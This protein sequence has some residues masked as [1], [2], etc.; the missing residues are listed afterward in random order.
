MTSHVAHCTGGIATHAHLQ[1]NVAFAMP[2]R[3]AAAAGY[4]DISGSS[5]SASEWTSDTL[6]SDSTHSAG[7]RIHTTTLPLGAASLAFDSSIL[8]TYLNESTLAE[9]SGTDLQSVFWQTG[10]EPGSASAPNTLPMNMPISSDASHLDQRML[11]RHQ[12][13]L[14]MEEER[15]VHDQH[16]VFWQTGLEPGSASAQQPQ[17]SRQRWKEQSSSHESLQQSLQRY[18]SSSNGSINSLQRWKEECIQ[19]LQRE[20]VGGGLL[21]SAPTASTVVPQNATPFT[22]TDAG[23]RQPVAQRQYTSKQATAAAPAAPPVHAVGTAESEQ[24][25]HE[26]RGKYAHSHGENSPLTFGVA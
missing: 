25:S 13:V 5:G 11:E 8:D 21:N 24:S 15:R 2:M 10:L 7:T 14:K 18:Q 4:I 19:A 16:Q 6:P 9:L 12:E 20:E 3:P 1:R 23:H 17:Q 26:R 22:S